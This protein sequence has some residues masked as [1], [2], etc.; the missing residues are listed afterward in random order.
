VASE[1]PEFDPVLLS[2]VRLGVVSVLLTRGQASFPELQGLLGL[3]QGNLSTH[4]KKLENAG[5]VEIEKAF[6]DRKPR[7]TVT[8][9][10]SGRKA[11]L[12]HV[13]QLSRIARE[14]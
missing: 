2:Q 7:T 1:G 5:Y 9:T 12:R 11:F 8:L 4:L 10:K 6:V 14:S 3:T 13:E